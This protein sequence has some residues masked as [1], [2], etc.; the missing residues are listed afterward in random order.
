VTSTPGA[1]RRLTQSVPATRPANATLPAAGDR[2]SS[3]TE[4]AMSIPRCPGPYGP[5]RVSNPR[6]TAPASGIHNGGTGG[7]SGVVGGGRTDRSGTAAGTATGKEIPMARSNA[8]RNS[9]QPRP[10]RTANLG[11]VAK[12]K[13][14]AV[15]ARKRR[16]GL[17]GSY[18]AESA[19][20][21]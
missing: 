6:T 18:L 20:G 4:A 8:R 13:L 3:P 11:Y 9:G 21:A 14:Q 17:L 16:S 5:A 15:K 19:N 2:A 10:R 1:T 12:W 7:G